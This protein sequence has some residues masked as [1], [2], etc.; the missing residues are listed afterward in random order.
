MDD[1]TDLMSLKYNDPRMSEDK[2]FSL[3]TCNVF[4][5]PQLYDEAVK[6]PQAAEWLEAIAE[7]LHAG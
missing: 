4:D 1:T 2:F 3:L 5:K 7:E 6:T